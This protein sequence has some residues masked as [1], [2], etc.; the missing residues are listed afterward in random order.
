MKFFAPL[1]TQPPS[2]LTAVVFIPE[3]SE[4]EPGSVNPHAPSLSPLAN[5]VTNFRRC[6]GVPYW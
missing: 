5:G 1:I 2:L 3:A 6:S 4:P